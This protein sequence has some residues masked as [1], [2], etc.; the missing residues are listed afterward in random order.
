MTYFFCLQSFFDSFSVTNRIVAFKLYCS[1][2]KHLLSHSF[3]IL[4]N[5]SLYFVRFKTMATH[6]SVCILHLKLLFSF[7]WTIYFDTFCMSSIIIEMCKK[8]F[9]KRMKKI[10][11]LETKS[12]LLWLIFI[13]FTHKRST[14]SFVLGDIKRMFN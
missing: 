1:I 10:F 2:H 8:E 11:S 5:K 9:H 12:N 3:L 14:K 7:D 4:H 13:S 6:F